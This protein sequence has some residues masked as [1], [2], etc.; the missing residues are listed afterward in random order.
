MDLSEIPQE[1]LENILS[2]LSQPATERFILQ[3]YLIFLF[4]IYVSESVLF[5]NVAVG[6]LSASQSGQK[7]LVN[8]NKI[9]PS[10][11]H[12]LQPNDK[13]GS[14]STSNQIEY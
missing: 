4:T 14:Y 5:D 9:K 10:L 8:Q 1:V 12:S 13:V 3:V 6:V 2:Y 7:K 11:P